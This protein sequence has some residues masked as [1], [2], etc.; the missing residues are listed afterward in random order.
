MF[1]SLLATE[2]EGEFEQVVVAWSSG[3][4]KTAGLKCCQNQIPLSFLRKLRKDR[5]N[6]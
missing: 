3:Q 5:E 1:A 2:P 4:R 6:D